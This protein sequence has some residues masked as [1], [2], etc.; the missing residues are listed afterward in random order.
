MIPR[1]DCAEIIPVLKFLAARRTE[2]ELF[3][4]EKD[5]PLFSEGLFRVIDE[6]FNVST[7]GFEASKYSPDIP[8][9]EIYIDMPNDMTITCKVKATYENINGMKESFDIDIDVLRETVQRR[10]A[11]IV[12]GKVD[13]TDI[14]VK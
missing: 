12:S 14:T 10:Q 2:N 9:F 1:S 4:A 13:L 8:K 11:D 3:I 6:F 7:D 5:L